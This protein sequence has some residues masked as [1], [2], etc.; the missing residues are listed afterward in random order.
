MMRR[1][2]IALAAGGVLLATAAVLAQAPRPPGVTG[3]APPGKAPLSPTVTIPPSVA[4]GAVQR[5]YST[6]AVAERLLVIVTVPGE[7]VVRDTVTV[8]VSPAAEGSD[9]VGRARVI[10]ALEAGP[11]RVY[12]DPPMVLVWH[13]G[14][15][16][17]LLRDDQRGA[18]VTDESGRAV[19]VQGLAEMLA[20]VLPPIPAPAVAL[21]DG[22]GWLATGAGAGAATSGTGGGVMMAAGWSAPLPWTTGVVWTK[23]TIDSKAEPAAMIVEGR[24]AGTG[25]TAPASG[26]GAAGSLRLVLDA[27][28][29]RMRSLTAE[30][31]G[32]AKI[33]VQATAITPG[34][35]AQ[36]LPEGS[37][38]RLVERLSELGSREGP[39]KS[40]P[41]A[42]GEP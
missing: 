42:A 13:A 24:H 32:G 18:V 6:G 29:G 35:P 30:F 1:W 36:W 10:V 17:V 26:L 16:G 34:E 27:K 25:A 41:P 4:L 2:S 22:S 15:A 8:R 39:V 23:A 33:E 40:E 31:A 19:R 9:A 14:S 11:L 3:E 37:R 28:T 38:R 20:A 5:A 7:P 21:V 12:A